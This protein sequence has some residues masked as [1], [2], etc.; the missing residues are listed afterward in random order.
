MS[1][2][3]GEL[4]VDARE[5]ELAESDLSCNYWVEAGAGTGKT[6]LLIRRLLHI[7]LSGSA[8]LSEIAAITFTEKAAAELKARLRDE[9]ERL[10]GRAPEEQLPLI[11]RALEELEGAL[12]T[13]IHSFAGSLLRERPVEAA[14]DPHYSIL[15]EGDLE[16]LL[17]E[18]WEDWFFSELAAAPEVLTRALTLG[19]TPQRLK[20]L[21][22]LLYRQR[23][24]V[25]EGSTPEPPALLQPFCDLL[26]ERLPELKALLGSCHQQEDRGY[27][28]LVELIAPPGAYS[29][30]TM[31]LRG[32]DT[33]CALSRRSLLAEIKKTG[34]PKRPAAVKKG[35][36]A[37]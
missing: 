12:I 20:E 10:A 9:L 31:G 22:R 26:A 14:V 24:L 8:Q 28:H 18:I 16:D 21:G 4:L 6:T 5:R 3:D 32:S 25:R 35:S 1:P 29:T 23:D 19:V 15:D 7:I 37:S 33:S 34:S 13:T 27:R 30:S 11:R 36:V 17:E 2:G